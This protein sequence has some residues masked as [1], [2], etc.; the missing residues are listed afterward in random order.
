MLS[1]S[2][3]ALIQVLNGCQS[4][5]LH[6]GLNPTIHTCL[7]TPFDVSSV[8]RNAPDDIK[9]ILAWLM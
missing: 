3:V 1:A 7:F 5:C 4:S 9:G 8:A 2:S 6:L